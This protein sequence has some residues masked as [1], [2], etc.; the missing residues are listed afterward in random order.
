MIKADW[1]IFKAKFTDN[2]QKNFE[3]LCYSLFCR[4]FQKGTGIF[5]YK[6]QSAIENNTIKEGEEI[7]GWQSKFY[8]DSLAKTTCRADVIDALKKAKRDYPNITKFIFYT[9]QEW[10]QNKGKEPQGKKDIE[11]KAN[12]LGIE[13][14][15]N[16]A[17]YFESPFVSTDNEIIAKH[18]F[19]LDKSIFD[20]IKN[21][22]AHSENI[23]NEIQ[24]AIAFND[25]NIKID[26]SGDLEKI[27]ISQEKVLILSGVGG[28]GKTA[29]I[30]DFY[31]KTKGKTPFYL[32]KATEFD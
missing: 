21:Q 22:Q 3:W 29:L 26:R 7:I 24:T 4:E 27:K 23:L 12:E 5:R 8:S 6:N 13:F 28:V 16:L 11:N 2:P 14:I 18:F 9:N 15:W 17:S 25:Q 1:N 10:G 32:F 31:E 20:L 30:K 19:S